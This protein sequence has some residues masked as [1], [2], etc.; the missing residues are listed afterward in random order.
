ME[1]DKARAN[2]WNA[3]QQIK[4]WTEIQENQAL[5]LTPPVA[6]GKLLRAEKR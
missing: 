5:L 6:R 3:I 1:K 4:D 2:M